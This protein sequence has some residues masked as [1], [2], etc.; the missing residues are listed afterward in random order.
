MRGYGSLLCLGRIH[1]PAVLMEKADN[2][3]CDY[4]QRHRPITESGACVIIRDACNGLSAAHT[5]ARGMHHDMKLENML[6]VWCPFRGRF[7]VKLADFGLCKQGIS[8]TRN[9]GTPEYTAPEQAHGYYDVCLDTYAVGLTS[10]VLRQA[11]Q[12]SLLHF[13]C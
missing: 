9:V 6:M 2:T 8:D 11:R 3:L 13:V 12:H 5:H 1:Q 7:V 10:P 4:W